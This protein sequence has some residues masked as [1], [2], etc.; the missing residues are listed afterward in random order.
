MQQQAWPRVGLISQTLKRMQQPPNVVVVYNAIERRENDRYA[1]ERD[2][3]RS[4]M[5]ATTKTRHHTHRIE[6]ES[7]IIV[8]LSVYLQFR[9]NE[10]DWSISIDI[11][12]GLISIVRNTSPSKNHQ[13]QQQRWHQRWP[14]QQPQQQYQRRRITMV[15]IKKYY[16]LFW[17]N[18]KLWQKWSLKNKVKKNYV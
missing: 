12:N 5:L 6:N 2:N 18:W 15:D 1:W 11:R 14:H 7:D 17:K 3:E 16:V 13:Q 4:A 8:W 9:S 10:T